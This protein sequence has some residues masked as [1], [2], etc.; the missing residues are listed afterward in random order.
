MNTPPNGFAQN[1][2]PKEAVQGLLRNSKPISREEA[3]RRM[4]EVAEAQKKK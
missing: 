2:D 1:R 4:E 3:I